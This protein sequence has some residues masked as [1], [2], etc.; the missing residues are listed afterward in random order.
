M[1]KWEKEEVSPHQQTFFKGKRSV[2]MKA[3]DR[4][5]MAKVGG[6]FRKGG[7]IKY[8]WDIPSLITEN[9]SWSILK[10]NWKFPFPVKI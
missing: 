5:E 10:F 1:R 8:T 3:M 9:F 6:N 2:L 7:H 4:E